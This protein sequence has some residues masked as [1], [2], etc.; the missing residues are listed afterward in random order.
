MKIIKL[1]FACVC[2]NIISVSGFGFHKFEGHCCE[3]D[4]I[5][6]YP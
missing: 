3:C 1:Q 6:N 4:Q 5:I 2:G